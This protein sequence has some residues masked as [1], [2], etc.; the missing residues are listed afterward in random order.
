MS[1]ETPQ[2]YDISNRD[3]MDVEPQNPWAKFMEYVEIVSVAR[4]VIEDTEKAGSPCLYYFSSD[5]AAMD[6]MI[7][8]KNG[9][10]NKDSGNI[11]F[12]TSEKIDPFTPRKYSV[13]VFNAKERTIKSTP[14]GYQAYD[15][16]KDAEEAA[17]SNARV[18]ILLHP[19]KMNSPS[20]HGPAI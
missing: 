16:P 12:V 2:Y 13:R 1:K 5:A 9:F 10:R 20:P 7:V 3:G 4:T 15:N 6:L 8:A 17:I 19:Q 14:N 18:D 11:Y